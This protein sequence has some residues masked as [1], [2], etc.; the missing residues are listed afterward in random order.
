MT[1]NTELNSNIK[2]DMCLPHT[3]VVKVGDFVI[4]V[5]LSSPQLSSTFNYQCSP[6]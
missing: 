2:F 6:V 5:S 4:I 3:K 1:I